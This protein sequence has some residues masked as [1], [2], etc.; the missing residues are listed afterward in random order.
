MVCGRKVIDILLPDMITKVIN[1]KQ[2]N[3][4]V[5]H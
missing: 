2:I 1:I 3:V 4:V 5:K